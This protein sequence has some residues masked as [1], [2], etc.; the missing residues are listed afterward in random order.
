MEMYMNY[1]VYLITNKSNS[2][3]Y[4]GITNNLVRRIYEHKGKFVEGFS[5][6]Y[7]LEKLIYYEVYNSPEDA[8]AREKQLKNW[9]RDKKLD[10][11]IKI[12]T[13]FND[14][15]DDIVK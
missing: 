1:Y 8:I 5:R 4:I 14:L 13:E 15:Y 12:N 10:L 11:I 3:F 7:N 9:R 2:V 6:R